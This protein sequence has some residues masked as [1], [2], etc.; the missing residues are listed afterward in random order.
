LNVSAAEL[1]EACPA[2]FYRPN[3]PASDR[4]I[5]RWG[6]T[7]DV[8][9]SRG[10]AVF[11]ECDA[12][13]RA[14][15]GGN[16]SGKTTKCILEIGSNCIGFRPWYPEDSPWRTR[17]L[18]K[19]HRMGRVRGIYVIANYELKMPD[20]MAELEKWWPRDW[21]EVSAGSKKSPREIRWFNGST[22]RFFS[23]K[24]QDKG[25]VEGTEADF[26]CY[27]EPPPEWMWTAINRGTVS[28][29]GRIFIGAT[30]LNKSDWFWETVIAP[31]E[32]GETD[33]IAVFWHSIWDNCAENGGL[34]TQKASRI[35]RWLHYDIK[36][37]DER[38][39]REHGHPMHVGGLVLSAFNRRTDI[40]DP[41]ELPF[42]ARI[43]S[44]IDPGGAK[45]MAAAWA[46]VLFPPGEDP[47]FHIFDES[48]DIRS[49]NDFPLF[50]EDFKSRE[51]GLGPIFHPSRS[52]YTVIDPAAN[53]P[54]KA[55]TFGRTMVMMLE[56]DYNIHTVEADKANK[57]ARLGSLNARFRTSQAKVWRNC[58]RAIYESGK[59][60]WDDTS[61]KLT[62][63]PDDV[64]DGVSYIESFDPVRAVFDVEGQEDHDI[65]LPKEYRKKRKRRG[66][67][68][69]LTRRY[70]L[71]A[72]RRLMA[73]KQYEKERA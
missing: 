35:Y 5:A 33:D 32:S 29:G 11:F 23:H 34:E 21:W 6:G 7:V 25:D 61:P 59:W 66:E 58:E 17:G 65:W 36:D 54:Q 48:Y 3:T 22:V 37:P 67:E 16:R 14:S 18:V 19:P 27:D 15:S 40:I 73:R 70:R 42:D 69:E 50:T 68:S 26:I 55:D 71:E 39:A 8:S 41:F 44:A 13:V 72:R 60:S 12:D 4:D 51:S 38:L 31:A 43:F 2:A 20:I 57:R 62:T 52:I 56:E 9:R 30:M 28:T 49:R 10:D 24:V 1:Q 64:W 63:G 46:A 47:E 45:P 53:Q